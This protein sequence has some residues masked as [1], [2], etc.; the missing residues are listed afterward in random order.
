MESSI[1]TDYRGRGQVEGQ[2]IHLPH[3]TLQQMTMRSSLRMVLYSSLKV[4]NTIR[5]VKI[6]DSN[7][8]ISPENTGPSI[9]QRERA[10]RAIQRVLFDHLVI[11]GSIFPTVPFTK[12]RES[13]RVDNGKGSYEFV[14][15]EC[16]YAPFCSYQSILLQNF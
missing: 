7:A 13:L 15:T 14:K 10:R 1:T 6:R 8:N 4:Y 11:G 5:Q 12:P 9:G 16:I 3:P 2:K